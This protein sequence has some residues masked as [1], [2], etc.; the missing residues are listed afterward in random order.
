MYI[1]YNKTRQGYVRKHTLK[2]A[3]YFFSFL[4]SWL[5]PLP[6]PPKI[7][8]DQVALLETRGMVIE[9]RKQ[10]EFYL[11]HLNYYRLCAYWLPFEANHSTH[12]FR[13][14]TTF[15][16]V[17]N[18]YI[19]DRQLRLHVLDAIERVEVSVRSNW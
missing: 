5:L 7:W 1:S 15:D 2:Q 3:G 6:N 10:A 4:K 11:Q 17:L 18:L 8:S 19:F 13:P 16:A 12:T 9:D 14:G